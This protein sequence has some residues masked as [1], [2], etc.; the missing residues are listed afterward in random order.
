MGWYN[1]VSLG[2]WLGWLVLGLL[3]SLLL[4]GFVGFG[5]GTVIV[6]GGTAGCFIVFARV[7]D[8]CGLV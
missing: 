4:S 5:L 2:F 3:G 7:S 6:L 1:I 8:L